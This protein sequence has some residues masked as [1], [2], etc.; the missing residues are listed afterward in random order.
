MQ[1]HIEKLTKAQSD[2]IVQT[3][4]RS[5]GERLKS[6]RKRVNVSQEEPAE[7]PGLDASTLSKYESG[8]RDMQI[9]LLPLTSIYCDFPMYEL[10]PREESRS[11]LDVFES[12]VRVTV[13]RHKRQAKYRIRHKKAGSGAG[14]GNS[15]R[16]LKGHV[17][18]V[19][20]H[21]VFEPASEHKRERN[22]LKERYR[23][24]S[25]DVDVPPC[26]GQEFCAYVKRDAPDAIQPVMDAGQLLNS[27]R[28]VPGK[29]GLR[30]PVADYI[31]DETV[32]NRIAGD[33]GDERSKRMYAFYHELYRKFHDE[34]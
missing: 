23:N 28:D 12:A 26:S 18:E 15:C 24:I 29:N 2:G 7:C 9:S 5:F 16:E 27:V 6:R 17:Y 31:I 14:A 25:I 8:T 22:S 1:K 20:G 11:I 3:F 30:D 4:L 33:A 21:E 34:E 32:I 13:E 10:F 19:D